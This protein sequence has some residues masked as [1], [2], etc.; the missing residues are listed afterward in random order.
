MG[1]IWSLLGKP[2]RDHRA[3][4][5]R[6]AAFLQVPG[7]AFRRSPFR[8]LTTAHV[9]RNAPHSVCLRHRA[10]TSGRAGNILR[11]GRWGASRLWAASFP[12]IPAPSGFSPAPAG[13]ATLT[14]RTRRPHSP[15]CANARPSGVRAS[16]RSRSPRH[17]SRMRRL[18]SFHRFPSPC[19]LRYAPRTPTQASQYVRSATLRAHASPAGV[20]E[21]SDGRTSRTCSP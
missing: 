7:V 3:K 14:S 18:P 5:T 17:P 11:S 15:V 9:R 19:A 10:A 6:F 13:P 8:L 4:N 2:F 20:Q 1:D 21:I 12:S 16:L